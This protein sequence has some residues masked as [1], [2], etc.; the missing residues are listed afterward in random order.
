MRNASRTNNSVVAMVMDQAKTGRE[1]IGTTITMVPDN[2]IYKVTAIDSTE[3]TIT[4]TEVLD[5]GSDAVADVVAISD[6]N[7]HIGHYVFN[8]N[9]K[10]V[11][12]V[13]LSEV[14]GK[15]YLEFENGNKICCGQ[16][17]VVK[18]L[19]ST[20]GSVI[21]VT[22]NKENDELVDLYTYKVQNDEFALLLGNFAP[23]AAELTMT[24]LDGIV[25]ITEVLTKFV[26]EK[27]EDGNVK[28]SY[29][30]LVY[31]KAYAVRD[32]DTPYLDAVCYDEYDDCDDEERN[33]PLV[34]N[35]FVV[36]QAGRKD[37]VVVSTQDVDDDARIVDLDKVRFTLYRICSGSLGEVVAKYSVEDENAKVYLGGASGSA[38]VITVKDANQIFI[39][40]NR[41]TLVVDDP[42]VVAAMKSFKY[43]DGVYSYTD[44][45]GNP[46]AMW[47][48]SNSDREEIAFTSV[49][50]DRGTIFAIVE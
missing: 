46:G 50:T 40:T 1:V 36:E 5:E 45:D 42:D 7:A 34:S 19:G 47:Y 35:M 4:V 41:G 23:A 13:T 2:K 8:P 9:E 6:K 10:P 22:E 17:K 18:V 28:D 38:P 32:G 49:T 14:N 48:Y 31:S 44:E 27:D 24:R 26:E 20:K 3:G 37:L 16:I 25:L 11:P 33:F 39:T 21:L 43:F 29:T 30:E 12:D 15:S